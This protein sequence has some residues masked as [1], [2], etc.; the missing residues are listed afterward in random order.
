MR[1]YALCGVNPFRRR[2]KQTPADLYKQ[3]KADQYLAARRV[4]MAHDDAIRGAAAQADVRIRHEFR[5]ALLT[6]FGYVTLELPGPPPPGFSAS[7]ATGHIVRSRRVNPAAHLSPLRSTRRPLRPS[8]PES[9]PTGLG[10][11]EPS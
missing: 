9:R 4:G 5:D 7:L 6:D 3:V 11:R 1:E 2:P 10:V 8:R